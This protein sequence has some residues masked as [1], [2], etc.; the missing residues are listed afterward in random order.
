MR[1]EPEH[2]AEFWDILSKSNPKES[3]KFGGQ[4]QEIQLVSL[5][6][7]EWEHLKN[8]QTEGSWTS[9]TSRPRRGVVK[10]R[11]VWWDMALTL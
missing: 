11:R 4:P 6:F 7:M 3:G 8:G 2:A 9:S 1:L 5:T 10:I